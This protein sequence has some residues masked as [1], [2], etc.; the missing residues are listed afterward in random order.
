MAVERLVGVDFSLDAFLLDAR[1]SA[2]SM[3]AS[4]RAT[5][6]FPAR[7][8]CSGQWGIGWTIHVGIYRAD[9]AISKDLPDGVLPIWAVAG[10]V[11]S[12]SVIDPRRRAEAT[13]RR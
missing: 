8:T 13:W 10:G 4:I 12:R 3:E 11:G 5:R 1:A 2:S 9:T 7:S 6:L